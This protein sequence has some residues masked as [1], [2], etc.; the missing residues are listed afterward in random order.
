MSITEKMSN[1]RDYFNSGITLDLKFREQV[2]KNLKQSIIRNEKEIFKALNQDLGKSETESYMSEVGLVLSEI[3]YCLKHFKKWAKP[4]KV[5]TPLAQ[6]PAKSFM[7]YEPRGVVLIMSPWNYPFMLTMEPLVGAICA[8]N[9]CVLKPSNYSPCT[10]AIIR[11]IISECFDENHVYVVLG[12]REQ[13]QELLDERFDYIFFTGGI[14]VGKVVAEKT[15]KYLTPITLELG[16]KSPCII[17]KSANV[18]LAAKRVVFGKFLNCGQTCI[19][20]DY[21]LVDN[22]VKQEFIECVKLE[23]V[24]MFGKNPIDN[25]LY[26]KIINQKHYD[27]IMGLI[28]S[29]KIVFGGKGNK[30]SNKIEPTIL[31]NVTLADAVMQEEIFGPVLPII[32]IN[33]LNEA[34]NIIKNFGKPLALYLFTTN[35]KVE[36]DILNSISFGGGCIN[37]TI[38]HIATSRMPFGGVG[39]SGLGNYHGKFSFDTFSHLKPIV[40]KSNKIDLPMRYQPYSKENYKII[41]MFLK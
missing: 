26:G 32:G 40:K 11:K 17:E 16:G 39:Y 7:V 13:N 31:N 14:T 9:C 1:L 23:I 38:I 2:L 3:S 37:D 12:G 18:K 25:N 36:K 30:E 33:G 5:R 8:G 10:S 29:N 21:C 19:A 20:P 34:K 22:S 35:K 28:D 6:F 41:R 15:S 27:R 4:K 24:K